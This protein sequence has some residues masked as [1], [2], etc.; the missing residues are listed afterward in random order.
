MPEQLQKIGNQALDWWKKFNTKQKA[1]LISIVAVIVIA[2]VILAA[3]MSQPNMVTLITCEDTKQA[4]EVKT[5]LT[6]EGIDYELSQDG[7]V[8]K[9]DAKNL[10]DAEILL[11]SNSI[12]TTGYDISNVTS[13]GF[14]STE[15]DK[16]KLYRLYLEERFADRLE[17]LSN[18][19]SATVNLDIPADD[20]TILARDQETSAAVILTLSGEMTE[21]QAATVA[22]YI[23]TEVGNSSTDKITIL[24]SDSNALFI[25]GSEDSTIGTA[26]SQYSLR[27]KLE[28]SIKSEVRSVITSSSMFEGV[29]IAM[30]LDMNFDAKSVATHE[31]YA[32]DG[33]TNGMIG[34]QSTYESESEGGAAAEPGTDSNGDNTTYVIQ[35]NEYTHSTVSDSTINYQ[36]NERITNETS[37]VGTINYDSSTISLMLTRYVVYKEDIL[38]ASGALDNMTF[39]EYEAA[40]GDPVRVDVDPDYY[41]MVANATGFSEDNITIIAYEKPLFQYSSGGRSWSDYMQIILAVLV[42]LLLGYVVFRSTRK[43]KVPE[44]EEELSVESLL[45]STKENQE[46]NLADIGYSEKSEVRLLIEKFVEENPE[47][48]AAL[49]RNWLSDEWE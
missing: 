30:N 32:P 13:G 39:E 41:T 46:D 31:Y 38:R 34:S 45:E 2:L 29:E 27:S 21:E 6:D 16:T 37:G 43:E 8:F 28:S 17:G 3:V 23:A 47:A 1:L 19:E 26:S 42:F 10:A 44:M 36:N 9:V 40:N 24:D 14:S 49:L 22:Q 35:D 20:G 15:A 12:P 25:G 33:Q 7:L 5:L 48:A 4:G 11:G 18:V